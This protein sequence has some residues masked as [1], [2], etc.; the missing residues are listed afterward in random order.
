MFTIL[1]GATLSQFGSV[2]FVVGM[3]IGLILDLMLYFIP[4]IVAWNKKHENVTGIFLINLFFGWTLIGWIVALIWACTVRQA[5]VIIVQQAV[6]N[7][8][9]GVK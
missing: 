3:L 6:T 9:E 8:L 7:N 5:P 4:W 1:F 2:L